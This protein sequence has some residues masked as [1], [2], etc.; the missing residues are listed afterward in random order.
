MTEEKVEEPTIKSPLIL[1]DKDGRQYFLKPNT[2]KH[3]KRDHPEILDPCEFIKPVLKNPF[4]IC[5]KKW[6]EAIWYYY[7]DHQTNVWKS[8][9]FRLIIVDNRKREIKTAFIVDKLKD[10]GE[11]IW[12]RKNFI[13]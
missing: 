10:D 12:L 7:S 13:N 4:A 9:L 6:N 1:E 11:C 2:Y 5:K 8:K 3:I